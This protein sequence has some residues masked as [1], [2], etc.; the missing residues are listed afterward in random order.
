MPLE[1]RPGH[2]EAPVDDEVRNAELLMQCLQLTDQDCAYTLSDNEMAGQI[3]VA[4][5]MFSSQTKA[6][7]GTLT[8]PDLQEWYYPSKEIGSKEARRQ[9]ESGIR[10]S[11]SDGY[12]VTTNSG[13]APRSVDVYAPD[14]YPYYAG[15]IWRAS[16]ILS[17]SRS[18]AW[19]RYR[20]DPARVYNIFNHPREFVESDRYEYAGRYI[21]VDPEDSDRRF[22]MNRE[23]YDKIW[24]VTTDNLPKSNLQPGDLIPYS[25]VVDYEL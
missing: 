9:I 19:N 21:A 18:E 6:P 25:Q 24:R 11:V 16:S 17:L 13:V 23:M 2:V 1:R 14:K 20:I 7:W 22:A 3:E 5:C 4:R 10:I 12:D 8:I 15:M